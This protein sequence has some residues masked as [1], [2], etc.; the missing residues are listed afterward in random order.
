MP[1]KIL[2]VDD[3]QEIADLIEVYL[4]NDGY[5]VQKF[6]LGQEA[7]DCIERESFDLAV[8]DVM[9]PDIDGFKIVQK[10]RE[11]H[12]FPVIMLTA[13]IEDIDKIT[14]LT[15]GADDYITK[16]FNPLEVVARIKTQLRRFQKYNIQVDY[17]TEESI[18]EIDI[19][20]LII[21]QTLHTCTLYGETISLTPLEFA[22]LW[23]LAEPNERAR[24]FQQNSCLKPFGEKNFSTTII[25]SWHISDACVKNSK[26]QHANQN[27]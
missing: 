21:N 23:Y 9:L 25:Q 2:L 27:L 6:Y 14:G 18:K 24:S 7:L 8:L 1:D 3:E 19:H 5:E 13:K 16:P 15:L 11:N 26:N 4:K 17:S 20:G 10:I 12:F 22:I